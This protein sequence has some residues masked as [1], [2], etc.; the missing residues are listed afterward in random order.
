MI[1]PVE[2]S[3]EW[4]TGVGIAE[5][6]ADLVQGIESGN[7]VD[8]TLGS[9]TTALEA[10]SIVMDPVGS[11]AS[12]LVSFVIEHVRPLQDVLDALAGDADAVASQS[13]TWQN[14]ARV[15]GEEQTV[16]QRE[17]AA[18]TAGWTGQAGDAYRTRAADTAALMSAAATA[19]SGLGSAI[20]LAGLVVAA[21]RETV[22]DLIADLVGRLVVWAA[23]ALTVVAAPAVAAQAATAAAKWA[24]R[25][26]QLIK[27]LV[28]TMQN[29]MPLLRRLGDVFRQIRKKL[30][31]FRN[32]SRDADTSGDGSGDKPPD[33]PHDTPGTPGDNDPT[34]PSGTPDP[35]A[36][37]GGRPTPIPE[38]E[39]PENR[40]ALQRENESAQTLARAGYRVEQNPTVPGDKNPDYLIEGRVFDNYAPTSGRAR[41][42]ASNLEEEK[43]LS[44]QADRVVLNLSGS[45]VSIDE[46]RAQLRDWPIE[47]L[48]EVIAIDR[49]GNI[50]NL[51]P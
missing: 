46:M 41:N 34:Q 27:Q 30:D 26:A 43:V 19:A 16:Y 1:A 49:S 13:K 39:A 14:I 10:L 22:R 25:I 47:G 5:S 29:L 44:G 48:K 38:G 20:E 35:D 7:W 51:Y 18:D 40:L 24:A 15:V 4:Y 21:V 2:D 32:R 11:V 9:T 42:I 28:R 23:E 6:V 3:T 45:S 50:I 36:T 12:G 8:I 31:D 37:P 17:A 33:D